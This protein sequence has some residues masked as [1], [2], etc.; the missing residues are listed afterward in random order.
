MSGI[1]F[2]L[3]LL[4]M[5]VDAGGQMSFKAAAMQG[6]G[7][8]PVQ[9]WK[10]MFSRP[11][12]WLGILCYVL[13]FFVWLAFLAYVPL[14]VAIMLGSINIVAVMLAGRLAFGER[15]NSWRVA[16]ILLITLGVAVVGIGG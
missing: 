1:A 5:L 14:S 13:E 4:N 15:L 7:L 12:I 2:F 8:N 16:G 9:H 10:H 6:I 3:W 11:F